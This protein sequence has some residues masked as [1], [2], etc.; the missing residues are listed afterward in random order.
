MNP[1]EIIPYA[2]ATVVV[3]IALIRDFA[4]RQG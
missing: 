3:I 4:R 1:Y 2:V